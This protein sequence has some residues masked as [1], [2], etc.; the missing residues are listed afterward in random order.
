MDTIQSLVEKAKLASGAASASTTTSTSGGTEDDDSEPDVRAV[1]GGGAAAVPA[2]GA[3]PPAAPVTAA[4]RQLSQAELLAAATA[5]DEDDSDL[6]YSLG[7]GAVHERHLACM[8]SMAALY[9]LRLIAGDDCKRASD[10]VYEQTAGGARAHNYVTAEVRATLSRLLQR[11]SAA[12][13]GAASAA[14]GPAVAP[15]ATQALAVLEFICALS[16]CSTSP[17]W[18]PAVTK[19][20]EECALCGEPADVQFQL[21]VDKFKA[22][23]SYSRRAKSAKDLR[24][25]EFAQWLLSEEYAKGP[26]TFEFFVQRNKIPQVLALVQLAGYMSFSSEMYLTQ[27]AAE[28][29]ESYNRLRYVV[30]RME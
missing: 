4:P 27:T 28:L 25:L 11:V 1:G 13:G 10:S 19:S 15:R 30:D 29:F 5:A 2:A 16:T 3:A 24:R 9:R 21:D 18:R 12:T 22:Y 6:E 26:K 20:A 8:A 17:R 14:G 23:A 7:G